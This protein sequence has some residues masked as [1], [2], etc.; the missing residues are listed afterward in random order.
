MS[1]I[2]KHNDRLQNKMQDLML[3]EQSLLKMNSFGTV[4]FVEW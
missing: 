2:D 3:Q 1:T 4:H